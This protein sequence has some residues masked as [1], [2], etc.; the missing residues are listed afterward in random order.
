MFKFIVYNSRSSMKRLQ[1]MKTKIIWNCEKKH[2]YIY[3]YKT[4]KGTTERKQRK[5]KFKTK[6][7]VCI[8]TWL[9]SQ[10]KALNLMVKLDLMHSLEPRQLDE[11]K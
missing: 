3:S 7:K 10:C 9:P 11:Q 8:V 1:E 5:A 6:K 2:Y 4:D